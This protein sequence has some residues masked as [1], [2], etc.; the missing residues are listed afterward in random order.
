VVE[1]DYVR[2]KGDKFV[3]IKEKD[4]DKH[5][6]VQKRPESTDK[7]EERDSG[8]ADDSTEGGEEDLQLT[9]ARQILRSWDALRGR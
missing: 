7:P 9:V 2:E 1:N 8:L 6:S 5:L 4:L 3:P